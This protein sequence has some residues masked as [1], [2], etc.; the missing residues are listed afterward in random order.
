MLASMSI[1]LLALSLLLSSTVQ[2]AVLRVSAEPP[3]SVE[4]LA[5][6]IRSYV[7]N[8]EVETVPPARSERDDGAPTTPGAVE[9]WLRRPGTPDDDAELVV[10]DGDETILSRLTGTARLE[11]LY[12]AAALKVQ[13]L[14]QRRLAAASGPPES[15]SA[16]A[17]ATN[18]KASGRL[19]GEAGLAVLVPSAGPTREG[20]RLG[21]GLGFARRWHLALSVYLEPEK[22]MQVTEQGN[23]IDVSAWELPIALQVGCDWHQSRWLGWVDVV[24]QGAL[25]RVSADSPGIVSNASV[26]FSPRVGLATGV[27]IAVGEVVHAEVR[28]AGLAVLADKRY[29][30]DGDVVWPAAG[31]LGLLELGLAYGA[32]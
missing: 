11:D 12:R 19:F 1:R 18:R 4:R 32:R 22:S 20:L 3:L 14:L 10:F 23:A 29:R 25:W 8:V 16:S 27:G 17:P 15:V 31:F 6:A 2:A 9:I 7:E 30:V 24:G 13:A 28:L 5:D 26:A 21:T